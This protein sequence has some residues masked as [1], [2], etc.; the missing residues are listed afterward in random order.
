[1]QGS[2][3]G[4]RLL[5]DVRDT[6]DRVGQMPIAGG[7]TRIPTRFED[8]P[9]P[10]GGVFKIATF[11]GVWAVNSN[12]TVTLYNTP[13]TT[14]TMVAVNIFGEVG[15][16]ATATQTKCAIARDGTA[17]YVIQAQCP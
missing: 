6:I 7:V 17:W 13:G 4:P 15:S 12:R 11:T 8:L 3:L 10:V 14:N 16:T 1:M 2:L 9:Q 5:Q